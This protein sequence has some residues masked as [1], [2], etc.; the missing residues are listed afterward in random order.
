MWLT[1]KTK[2][3]GSAWTINGSEELMQMY[4]VW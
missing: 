2:L 3:A 1:I 4:V